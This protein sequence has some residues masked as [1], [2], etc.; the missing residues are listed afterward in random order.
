MIDVAVV[1]IPDGIVNG[2][3]RFLPRNFVVNIIKLEWLLIKIFIE[4]Q[5]YQLWQCNRGLI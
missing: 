5:L 3:E 1:T 4:S 2:P